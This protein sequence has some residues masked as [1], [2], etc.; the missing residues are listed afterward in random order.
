MAHGMGL[1][2]FGKLSVDRTKVWANASKCRE[3]GYGRIL[4]NE[5]GLEAEVGAL[6]DR[7]RDTG[8]REDERFG[9]SFRGDGL[10]EALHRRGDRLAAVRAAKGHLE[11]S[12]READDARG[13]RSEWKRNPKD[14]RPYKRATGSWTGRRRTTSPTPAAP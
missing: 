1:A 12:Q 14:G 13:C 5:R 4:R 6:P 10:P 2:R 11:A 3:T 9:E 7:A 8:A